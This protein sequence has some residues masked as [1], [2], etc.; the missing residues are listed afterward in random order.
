MKA[1]PRDLPLLVFDGDCGFCR[2]WINRWRNATGTAVEYVPFQ[3]AASTLPQIPAATFTQSV[4]F[5]WPS[6]KVATGA[7]AVFDLCTYM[8]RW[9]WLARLS[10]LPGFLPLARGVY[11]WVATHRSTVS[12]IGI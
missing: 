4:V 12:R 10:H 9:R 6:G 8:P 1:T 5:V 3:A 7:D 11:R 2:R